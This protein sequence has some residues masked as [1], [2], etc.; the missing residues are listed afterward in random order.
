MTS[1]AYCCGSSDHGVASTRSV[2][3]HHQLGGEGQQ[4]DASREHMPQGADDEAGLLCDGTQRYGGDAAVE[5]H[6][7]DRLRELGLPGSQVNAV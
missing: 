5:D 6:L 4:L 1:S 2:A 7:P 3:L